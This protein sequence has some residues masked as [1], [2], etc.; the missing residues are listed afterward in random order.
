M[1]KFI[2]VAEDYYVAVEKI[3]CVSKQPKMIVID[4]VNVGDTIVLNYETEDECTAFFDV[5]LKVIA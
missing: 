3:V 2:S 5:L 1:L 4:T